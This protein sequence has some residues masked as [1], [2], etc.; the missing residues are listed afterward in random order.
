MDSDQKADDGFLLTAR[1]VSKAFNA[2]QALSDFQIDIGRGE[3]HSLMGENGSGKSTFIK[4]IAGVI[5]PDSGDIIFD[6]VRYGVDR[7]TIEMMRAGIEVIYQDLSLYPNLSVAENIALPSFVEERRWRVDWKE[8][9]AIAKRELELL[10]RHTP[11]DLD[12]MVEDLSMA[13][14][15]IVAIVRALAHGAKLIVMDEPTTALTK[16]EVDSLLGVINDLKQRGI[17]TLFVSHKFS[18]VFGVA[19]R[20]T[21]IRDG[22][23]VAQFA[24]DELTHE[25]LEYHMTGKES[26]KSAFTFQGERKAVPLLDVRGLTRQNHFTDINFRI[27]EGEIVGLT[28]LLG[29]GRTELAMSLFGL[30]PPDSGEIFVGGDPVS[31]NSAWDAIRHGISYLPEDRIVQ[32]LF[33]QKPI[34][35]NITVTVL[36]RLL[37]RFRLIDTEKTSSVVD[38]WLQELRIKTPSADLPVNSLSGGNQQRVVLSK[39][40]AT[41]PRVFILDN[42]TVGIDIAS[43]SYIHSIIRE[44]AARGMGILII[45]D[46]ILE[47]LTNC[48][49]IM[50][51][52]EGRIVGEYESDST[53]EDELQTVVSGGSHA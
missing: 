15:Q 45:S 49:R 47:V 32:G 38:R 21:V 11:F 44:L 28:G 35:E 30:N 22:K 29:S 36:D 6:G 53:A 51:M 18:E 13:N 5:K 42:P 34:G 39:W 4:V 31:I 3:I 46:E 16:P 19:E 26:S 8:M 33:E 48:N 27:W 43:K 37:G 50:V 9:R 20:I 10:Q 23:F 40:L 7:T 25:G 1:H 52:A 24:A 41:N 17:S 2:V 14:R 12:A